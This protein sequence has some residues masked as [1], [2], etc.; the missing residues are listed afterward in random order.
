MYFWP[1][2]R[3]Q[4]SPCI[5]DQ[6]S[7]SR[8]QTLPSWLRDTA[9]WWWHFPHSMSNKVPWPCHQ[10]VVVTSGEA[11]S[12]PLQPFSMFLSVGNPVKAWPHLNNFS[13]LL[14]RFPDSQPAFCTPWAL[15][16][17]PALGITGML[18]SQEFP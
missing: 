8:F 7:N 10:R 12:Q 5:V 3:S 6:S 11:T 13:L 17:V 4:S 2:D 16:V 14:S 9:P 18:T 1:C 15:S